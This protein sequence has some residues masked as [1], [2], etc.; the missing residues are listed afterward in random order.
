M[1]AVRS[2]LTFYSQKQRAAP[3]THSFQEGR[4]GRKSP[5]SQIAASLN[6]RAHLCGKMDSDLKAPRGATQKPG[7]EALYLIDGFIAGILKAQVHH[8]VLQR[9]THVEFQ[10]KIINA[11]RKQKKE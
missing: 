3:P 2:I 5:D 10:G 4:T 7:H 8:R 11:L 9:A 6:I 1:L